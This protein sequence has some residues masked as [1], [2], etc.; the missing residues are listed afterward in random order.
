MPDK[1]IRNKA[2]VDGKTTVGGVQLI[3]DPF[4]NKGT[5]FTEEERDAMGLR[6]LLPPRV[7]SMDVQVKRVLDNLS[8]KQTDLEKYL[9]LISL[10]DENRTL[11]Y[12]VVVDNIAEMMPIILHT[13]SR[14]SVSAVF[15]YFSK[16]AGHLHFCKRQG[17]NG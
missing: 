8:E 15:T 14:A 4:L 7:L 5:A 13:N 16:T 11:F 10:Q 17:T 2:N 12:R 3:H 9:Y 1:K 6:G